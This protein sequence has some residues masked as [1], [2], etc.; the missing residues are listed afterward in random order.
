MGATPEGAP[1]TTTPTKVVKQAPTLYMD[2]RGVQAHNLI[3]GVPPE[4]MSHLLKPATPNADTFAVS[5]A[6]DGPAFVED[7]LDLK[8]SPLAYPLCL[9]M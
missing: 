9:K 1:Q 7:G 8:T 2:L 3:I 6:E 5:K 4:H